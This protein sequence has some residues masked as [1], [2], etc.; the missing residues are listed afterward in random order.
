MKTTHFV[1]AV[2]QPQLLE[3]IAAIA[4]LMLFTALPSTALQA[5]PRSPALVAAQIVWMQEPSEVSIRDAAGNPIRAAFGVMLESG[6][7]VKTRDSGAEIVLVPNGSVIVLDNNTTFRIDSLHD[8]DSNQADNENVFSLIAGKLRLI[9]AK[10]TGSSYSVRTK[11]AVA[12]VR[13]T[14]FYRM[15]APAAGRDW[16]CVTEGSVQFDSPTGDQGV[17]VSAGEFVD[18][19]KG[20]KT[21]QADG[22]WLENNL[23]LET[24]HR[25][26]LPPQR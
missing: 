13:G 16:L 14:D 17:L 6:S 11:T 18:L 7:T 25:A 19:N 2:P 4:M 9:A 12:G 21:A 15:Y 24:L 5:S 1:H 20:F 23:T 22:G 10:I 26:V 8:A 3:I